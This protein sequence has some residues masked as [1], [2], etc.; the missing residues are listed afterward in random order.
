MVEKEPVNVV[1]QMIFAVIPILD[2]YASY[3]IQKLRLWLLIFWAVG[4][5][6]GLIYSE[7]IQSG[8]YLAVFL[9][10]NSDFIHA[11]DYSIFIIIF[12]I[13]QAIVMR[14]LSK[15]WNQSF[16]DENKISQ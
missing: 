12:A 8:G 11:I 14:R 2:I 7:T 5:I 9:N 3:K 13:L 4:A 16:R 15:K 1:R 10:N 6:V